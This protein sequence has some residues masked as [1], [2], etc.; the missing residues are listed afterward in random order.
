LGF[1]FIPSVSGESVM[2]QTKARGYYR[3]AGS[4]QAGQPCITR[5]EYDSA[6]QAA[7]D[8][9]LVARLL[10]GHRIVPAECRVIANGLQPVGAIDVCIDAAANKLFSALAI[11]ATTFAETAGANTAALEALGVSD[12]DRDIFFLI[13]SGFATAPVGGKI[14]LHL[15]QVPGIG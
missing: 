9:V 3:Q 1:T 6:I 8:T 2:A 15:V 5:H 7:A 12:A 10:A 14:T 11:T 4:A 13:N